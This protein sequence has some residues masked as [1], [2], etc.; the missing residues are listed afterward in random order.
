[1]N[2]HCGKCQFSALEKSALVLVVHYCNLWQSVVSRKEDFLD[3][4]VSR[5]ELGPCA[6]HGRRPFV[7]NENVKT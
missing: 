5:L 2:V 7:T 3:A 4:Y 6:L 1:M